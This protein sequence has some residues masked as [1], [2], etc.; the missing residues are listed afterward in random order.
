MEKFGA[1]MQPDP[2]IRRGDVGM[3][4]AMKVLKTALRVLTAITE[5]R[6]PDPFDV[7]ELLGYAPLLRELSLDELACAVIRHATRALRKERRRPVGTEE[8][9]TIR[10]PN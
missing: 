9:R 6:P 8:A 5:E 1:R 2:D 3:Q 4:E 10:E 7:Y